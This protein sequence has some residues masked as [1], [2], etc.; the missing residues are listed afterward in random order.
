MERMLDILY[1]RPDEMEGYE[2][3]EAE[4]GSY[5]FRKETRENN[6]A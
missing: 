5:R 6:K 1:K 2:A 3:M 4:T